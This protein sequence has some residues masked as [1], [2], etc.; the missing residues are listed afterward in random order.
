MASSGSYNLIFWL[1][2][3]RALYDWQQLK[4]WNISI[5]PGLI[6]ALEHA[7]LKKTSAFDPFAFRFEEVPNHRLALINH[8]YRLVIQTQTNSTATLKPHEK[9]IVS[10]NS[11][12]CFFDVEVD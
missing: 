4:G 7:A 3:P 1:H 11:V 6:A 2:Q 5:L 8:D 12:V 9:R 10:L